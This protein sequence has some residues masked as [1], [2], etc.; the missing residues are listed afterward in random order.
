MKWY[1]NEVAGYLHLGEISTLKPN[2]LIVWVVTWVQ[3][4]TNTDDF[5]CKCSINDQRNREI[6]LLALQSFYYYTQYLTHI[7]FDPSLFTHKILWLP[8]C[9][10][11][12][13]GYWL[14]LRAKVLA[15]LLLSFSAKCMSKSVDAES[16]IPSEIRVIIENRTIV[17]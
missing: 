1:V 2:T 14:T 6:F 13:A 4:K 5:K 12:L 11:H 17:D 7:F 8:H 16:G 10:V 3:T 9:M 15:N